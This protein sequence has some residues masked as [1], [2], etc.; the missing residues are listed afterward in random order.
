MS[1]AQIGVVMPTPR[2]ED[3]VTVVGAGA[4]GTAMAVIAARNNREVVLVG[5]D[6]AQAAH[7][8]EHH[9]N[10]R[11]L[12]DKIL[13]N[14]LRATTDLASGIAGASYII[15]AIPAQKTPQWLRENRDLIPADMLICSTSKGL[16]VKDKKLLSEAMVDALGRDQPL[17]F[18]SGPSFAKELVDEQP[19]AVVVASKFLYHAVTVQR[20]LST[21]TFRVY[22]TQ[23]VVGVQLGGALKN[24]LAIGAGMIEGRGFGINTLSAYV[25]RSS[26]ELQKLC[27][28]MGGRPE[29][30]SGLSGIGDLM[31]TAFGGLSRN[32]RCGSRLA[33]GEKIEDICADYTVEGV[34]TS[35][36]AIH[37][38]D[39]C[40]LEVPIFRVVDGVIQGTVA[41]DDAQK[42]LM[43]RPLST[44]SS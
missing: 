44:E 40:G 3:K 15:H 24:P 34:P 18:L 30:I 20:S 22:T 42:L 31:L 12:S 28:A 23:D 21:L 32:R 9:V 4:F 43:G 8:N 27:I 25:T 6:E 29:T 37:F 1:E 33:K 26:L 14:N 19:S 13:P 35:A 41:I 11:Y 38:A 36:V 5:R 17:A 2:A 10:P 16:Y 7:I 39:M